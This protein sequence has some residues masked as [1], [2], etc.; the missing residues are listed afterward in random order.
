MHY[1][2]GTKQPTSVFLWISLHS[3]LNVMLSRYS[4]EWNVMFFFFMVYRL[5]NPHAGCW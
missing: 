2:G 5:I 4:N 1:E 3:M